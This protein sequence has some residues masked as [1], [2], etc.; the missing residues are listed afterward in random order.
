MRPQYFDMFC[1]AAKVYSQDECFHSFTGGKQKRPK[2]F[3]L[4][5][6]AIIP[7]EVFSDANK[8]AQ[9]RERATA[10]HV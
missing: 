3:S 9:Q 6:Y 8:K 10:V 2:I 4:V 7:Q 1:C 5:F